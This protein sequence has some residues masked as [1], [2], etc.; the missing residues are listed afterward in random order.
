MTTKYDCIGKEEIFLKQKNDNN[1]NEKKIIKI[2]C[3]ALQKLIK[4]KKKGKSIRPLRGS[5]PGPLGFSG[6]P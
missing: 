2:S 1:K 6:F 4:R 3:I 5:N